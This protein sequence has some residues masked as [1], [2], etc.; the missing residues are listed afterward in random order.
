MKR[1]LE[2][3]HASLYMSPLKYWPENGGTSH[4]YPAL[5]FKE[6]LVMIFV[7]SL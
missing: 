1:S 2:R 4:V 7:N 6:G 5:K 3:K